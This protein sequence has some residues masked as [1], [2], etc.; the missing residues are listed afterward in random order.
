VTA[1]LEGRW[2]QALAQVSALESRL[3]ALALDP[4]PAISAE[5]KQR[6]G[7]L[8]RDLK[9]LWEEPQAAVA[10]GALT[11]WVARSRA[12]PGGPASNSHYDFGQPPPGEGTR[13]TSPQN[14]PLV[15]RVP[16]PGGPMWS[17]MRIAAVRLIGRDKR[18]GLRY[19]SAIRMS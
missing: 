2:N 15:G 5:Q 14:R 4:V 3:E 17:I 6:L 13:P 9:R 1:E 12:A 16:S 19:P 8:G 10:G 11:S 7:E 18:S